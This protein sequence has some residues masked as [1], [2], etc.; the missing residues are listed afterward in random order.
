M[1]TSLFWSRWIRNITA[2][3]CYALSY[4]S[5]TWKSQSMVLFPTLLIGFPLEARFGYLDMLEK[6]KIIYAYWH[7]K[8]ILY[9]ST[10]EIWWVAA[11]T[12]LIEVGLNLSYMRPV[13]FLWKQHSRCFDCSIF[14][15]EKYI[16][17]ASQS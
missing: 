15:I 4:Q 13:I 8:I 10:F 11:S 2:I 1:T 5:A 6:Y 7:L 3:S 17:V 14:L 12:N 16:M 9:H